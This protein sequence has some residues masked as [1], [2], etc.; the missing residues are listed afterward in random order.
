MNLFK[1]IIAGILAVGIGGNTFTAEQP[2]LEDMPLDSIKNIIDVQPNFSEVAEY[3]NK[4]TLTSKKLKEQIKELA[5]HLSSYI[6]EKFFDNKE[7]IG[8]VIE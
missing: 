3:L 6:K 5:P 7:F 4:L 1:L 8:T 2:P